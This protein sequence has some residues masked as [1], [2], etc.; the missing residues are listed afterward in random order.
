[1]STPEKELA[2]AE[3]S[4]M[5]LE[6][7]ERFLIEEIGGGGELTLENVGKWAEDVART[8]ELIANQRAYVEQIK[9]KK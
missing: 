5:I 3:E 2:E 6:E 9:S 4:L 8:R 1:M 7:T